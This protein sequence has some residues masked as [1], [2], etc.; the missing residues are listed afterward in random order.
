MCT[1]NSKAALERLTK[2][3]NLSFVKLFNLHLFWR[4]KKIAS[5]FA[6]FKFIESLEMQEN[7]KNLT[8]DNKWG[9]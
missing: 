4:P 7:V 6:A 1:N 8:T 9:Q 5:F 3:R 2:S